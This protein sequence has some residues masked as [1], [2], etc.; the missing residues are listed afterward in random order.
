MYQLRLKTVLLNWLQSA[1]FEGGAEV[2]SKCI[3]ICLQKL[4]GRW[5]G[6]IFRSGWAPNEIGPLFRDSLTGLSKN[7]GSRRLTSENWDP[8]SRFSHNSISRACFWWL[9]GLMHNPDNFS[10]NFPSLARIYPSLFRRRRLK[11]WWEWVSALKILN[12]SWCHMNTLTAQSHWRRIVRKIRLRLHIEINIF[13]WWV[14]Q[15]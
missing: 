8:S 14:L 7:E 11:F 1:N 10:T 15:T 3:R 6:P 5:I 13:L 4:V 2:C 9:G 12:Q